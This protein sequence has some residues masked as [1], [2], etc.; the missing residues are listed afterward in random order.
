MLR[1]ALE[2]AKPTQ[3]NRISCINNQRLV[4]IQRRTNT[5]ADRHVVRSFGAHQY[6]SRW[7][8]IPMSIGNDR[9]HARNSS[10]NALISQRC[11]SRESPAICVFRF[12]QSAWT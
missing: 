5:A 12:S 2:V 3:E 1:V 4:L 11:S 6:T 9:N 7:I 10:L 8:D